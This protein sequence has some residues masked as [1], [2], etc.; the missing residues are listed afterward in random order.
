MEAVKPWFLLHG[1]F[2]SRGCEEL[3]FD[4]HS[5][6]TGDILNPVDPH[7]LL[8]SAFSM[9]ELD[10]SDESV[11]IC[12]YYSARCGTHAILEQEKK[13]GVRPCSELY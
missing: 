9:S 10:S 11:S 6:T 2:K 8:R 12:H 1:Y 13:Q 4:V 7:C 5:E 3:G